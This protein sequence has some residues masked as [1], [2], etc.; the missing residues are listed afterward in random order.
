MVKE[1]SLNE[2]LI[3]EHPG[4]RAMVAFFVQQIGECA[5]KLSDDFKSKHPEIEWG[6]IVGFRHHIVHAYGK[7]I[8]EILWDTVANDIPELSA[9]CANQLK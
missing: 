5:S 2:D 8:P 1:F 4:Y 9:F 6:A 7:V 3:R